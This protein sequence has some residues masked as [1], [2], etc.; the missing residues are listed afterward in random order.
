MI[1]R[2]AAKTKSDLL[3]VRLNFGK[4]DQ[5]YCSLRAGSTAYAKVKLTPSRGFA[6]PPKCYT[7]LQLLSSNGLGL[8]GSSLVLVSDNKDRLG[9]TVIREVLEADP[10]QSSL[11]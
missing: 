9:C 11:N 2:Y 8:A 5:G 7:S 4:F 10:K 1:N 3:S 6:P